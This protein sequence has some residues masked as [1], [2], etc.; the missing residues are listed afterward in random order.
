MPTPPAPS[1]RRGRR[2]TTAGLAKQGTELPG[3]FL[4]DLFV[5]ALGYAPP[6]AAD[7]SLN[8]EESVKVDGKVADALL[9]RFGAGE[10]GRIVAE[11]KGPRD[12]PDRPFAGRK[13]SALADREP[14]NDSHDGCRHSPL[15]VQQ[16]SRQQ[17]GR[18]A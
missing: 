4:N 2:G 16:S 6:P 11:G 18:R 3:D 5:G 1:W 14:R 12:P 8:R 7:I 13:R 9:G 15:G 10:R 17:T